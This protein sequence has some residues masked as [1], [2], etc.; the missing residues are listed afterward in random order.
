MA[1]EICQEIYF[2]R[3]AAT[4]DMEARFFS[5]AGNGAVVPLA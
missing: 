1:P 4:G 2:S 5:F 3:V